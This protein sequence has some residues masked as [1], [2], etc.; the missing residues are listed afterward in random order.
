MKNVSKFKAFLYFV[1]QWR[2]KKGL[3]FW[4]A[5]FFNNKSTI[6]FGNNN[7]SSTNVLNNV[8]FLQ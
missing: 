4:I 2:Y 3:E 1:L 5:N 7:K 6:E 8:E